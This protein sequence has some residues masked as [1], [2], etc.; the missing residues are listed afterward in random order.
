MLDSSSLH[1]EARLHHPLHRLFPSCNSA[2]FS[3]FFLRVVAPASCLGPLDP[4]PRSLKLPSSVPRGCCSS[5]ALSCAS[6]GR[7]SAC[8]TRPAANPGCRQGAAQTGRR[9]GGGPGGKLSL[10]SLRNQMMRNGE[11]P[12][13]GPPLEAWQAREQRP[14]GTIFQCKG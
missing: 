2:L 4:S 10:T 9:W 11:P 1:V 8:R 5:C 14:M 7:M 6:Q 12:R 3:S 13:M